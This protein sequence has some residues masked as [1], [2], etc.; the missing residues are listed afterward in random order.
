MDYQQLIDVGLSPDRETLTHRL[1]VLAESM[2]FGLASGVLIRGRFGSP[3]ALIESFG[4]T[5]AAFSEASRSL[6]KALRDP[7]LTRHLQ[8]P[9]HMT[10]G[11]A[12]YVEAGAT[13][14][15][16]IQ[17]AFG[18]RHGVSVSF[19][20][21]ARAEAFV[22]GFDRPDALPEGPELL[23][24][25]ATLQMIAMHAQEAM[26]RLVLT[27]PQEAPV[28]L[29]RQERA[30]LQRVATV[31]TKRGGL[32]SV[33]QCASP[34]LQ[35]AIRKL[36]A[37]N[38]PRAVVRAI[39]GGLIERESNKTK[40]AHGPLAEGI[41]ASSPSSAAR[42]DSSLRVCDG[43]GR[44][45]QAT[46]QQIL[47]AAREVVGQKMPRGATVRSD[48]LQEYLRTVL[49]GRDHEVFA[50]LFLDA[51]LRLIEYVEMF[52][53]TI[54]TA[55]VYPREVVKEALRRNA[56]AAILVHNHPSGDPEPSRADQ[57]LTHK[58]KNALA[59]IEVQILD[60]I[61]VAGPVTVSLAERGLI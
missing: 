7:L 21:P 4:N 24:M 53:G 12:L 33:S 32:V 25:Q 17:S 37:P 46:P 13:D 57:V 51:Q 55:A 50:V 16:D 49:A 2:G 42:R 5:P 15:W 10:Y 22:F 41:T 54:D 27:A 38:L 45:H 60:H 39:D 1:V 30:A 61:I 58:L 28:E 59:L 31:Y 18:Y 29:T 36:Q 48:T 34:D 20:A 43:D 3:N 23:H 47:E 56:A 11:Q 44:C 52:R 9:G 6:E 14:L 40:G 35:G 8:R 19:H 26:G